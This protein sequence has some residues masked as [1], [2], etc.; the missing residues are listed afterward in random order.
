M[1]KG[2]DRKFEGVS[3]KRNTFFFMCLKRR[4]NKTCELATR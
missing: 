4:T 2:G 3:K 1:K